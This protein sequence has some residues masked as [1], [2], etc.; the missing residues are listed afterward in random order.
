[1]LPLQVVLD[2]N[3]LLTGLRSTRGA[4]F[5]LLS[6]L[7]SGKFDIHLSVPLVVEYEE[8]L[9]RERE[10]LDLTHTDVADFLDY[11]CQVAHLHEVY[12]LWRPFLPDPKDEMILDLAVKARCE[13]IVSYNKRDFPGVER[14]GIEVVTS[15]EFLQKIGELP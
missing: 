2:T 4:S 12:F 9:E 11:I 7:E 1:M 8:V 15:K 5:K 3:V 13:H 10:S 14:F 6:L